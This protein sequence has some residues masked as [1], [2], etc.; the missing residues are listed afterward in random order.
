MG[1]GTKPFSGNPSSIT[2]P[3]AARP[4]DETE[5]GVSPASLSVLVQLLPIFQVR[6]SG[7]I[8]EY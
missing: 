4:T 3:E 5:C 8:L 1:H 2:E 7:A 6:L